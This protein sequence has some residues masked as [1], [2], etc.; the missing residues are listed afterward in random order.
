MP[1][2][3][4]RDIADYENYYQ[5]S[6]LDRVRSLDRIVPD[7]RGGTRKLKR[8]ILRPRSNGSRLMIDLHKDGI[9]TTMY[10]H[11]LVAAAWIGPCPDGMEVC[12]GPN[13]QLDNSVYNLRYDTRTNNHIDKRRDGTHRGRPVRRGDGVEFINMHIAAEESGCTCSNICQVCKGKRK[14]T[15]GFGWEYIDV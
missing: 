7:P 6:D 11:R 14:S 15:G 12:H 2:E 10:V 4:W 13:G 3:M 8:K 9:T 1:S 5:V